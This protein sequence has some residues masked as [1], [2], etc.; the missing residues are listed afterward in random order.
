MQGST[1]FIVG[2]ESPSF[3]FV[4][5]PNDGQAKVNR[6][7]F[8]MH[9]WAYQIV[10]GTADT[11]C[12]QVRWSS[13]LRMSQ[14]FL[15]SSAYLNCLMVKCVGRPF[16]VICLK[17]FNVRSSALSYPF[18]APMSTIFSIVSLL[19][20]LVCKSTVSSGSRQLW[21]PRM[22]INRYECNVWTSTDLRI[23]QMTQFF[24]EDRR[25]GQTFPALVHHSFC[26]AY[27]SIACVIQCVGQTSHD[28]YHIFR[29]YK[30]GRTDQRS[31]SACRVKSRMR[32]VMT[33]Y[34]VICFAALKKVHNDG[35]T[36]A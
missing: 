2:C 21:V 35:I 24:L 7:E 23:N 3:K 28:L 31:R 14:P 34:L 19:L 4:G 32:K 6:C 29:H 18:Q 25:T 12:G 36:M 5:Q 22:R 30:W 1:V 26:P 15:E 16:G 27:R 9:L 20:V 11:L 17:Y 8:S 13:T 10:Q 33:G